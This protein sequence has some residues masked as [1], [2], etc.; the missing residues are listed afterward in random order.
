MAYPPDPWAPY[1]GPIGSAPPKPK[2]L[3]LFDDLLEDPVAT[4]VTE[5]PPIPSFADRA[6][7]LLEPVTSVLGAPKRVVD[8]AANYYSGGGFRKDA[9]A[10][11]PMPAGELVKEAALPADEAQDSY[12]KSI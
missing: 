6:L 1:L 8:I 7:G 10:G 2:R 4:P 11:E 12:L 5:P 3:G 9:L